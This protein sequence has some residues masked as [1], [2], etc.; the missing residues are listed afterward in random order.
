MCDGPRRVGLQLTRA[1]SGTSSLLGLPTIAHAVTVGLVARGQGLPG[2]PAVRPAVNTY[3][4]LSTAVT[5]DLYIDIIGGSGEWAR[6]SSF[7]CYLG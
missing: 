4:R 2:L 6:V 3:L 1:V 7:S 5:L